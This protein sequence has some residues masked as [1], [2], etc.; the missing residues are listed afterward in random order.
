MIADV[1]A[2]CVT[3]S[4]P[5]MMLSVSEKKISVTCTISV[6]CIYN[7]QTHIHNQSKPFSMQRVKCFSEVIPC[8]RPANEKRRYIATSSLT[9]WAH[10]QNDPWSLHS[11]S[12]YLKTLMLLT[13]QK[14]CTIVT[15]VTHIQYIPRNTHT[16]LLCLNLLQ[17]Y[18]Q[19]LMDS[20]WSI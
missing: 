3:L 5:A 10:T 6:Y 13:Y 1:L 20:L 16:V 15:Y 11:H 9:G 12:S 17:W 4:S 19:S 18:Y 7:M 2:L 8:I 14:G